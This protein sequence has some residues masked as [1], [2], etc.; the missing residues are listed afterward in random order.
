MTAF[1]APGYT[2]VES[3]IKHVGIT[4]VINAFRFAVYMGLTENVLN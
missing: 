2:D 3:S 1:K 4:A